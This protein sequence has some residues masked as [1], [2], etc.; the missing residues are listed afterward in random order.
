MVSNLL[1]YWPPLFIS[2]NSNLEN[3]STYDTI[4]TIASTSFTEFDIDYSVYRYIGIAYI[5][6]AGSVYNLNI[7]PVSLFKTF[8]SSNAYI[9]N[10]YT[11]KRYIINAYY[12]ENI[13]V[14]NIN[15]TELSGVIYGIK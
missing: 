3:L 11:T 10:M 9:N 15:T 7:I 5:N 6:T 4:G 8:T 2:L 1:P 12:K 14:A 13:I